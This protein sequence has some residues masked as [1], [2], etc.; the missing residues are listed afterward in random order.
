[1]HLYPLLVLCVLC[2]CL[3]ALFSFDAQLKQFESAGYNIFLTLHNYRLAQQYGR[4]SVGREEG[5]EGE[6]EEEMLNH[7]QRLIACTH[8]IL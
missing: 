4:H 2:C 1:M 7:L 3:Y 6:A 8:Y 5:E